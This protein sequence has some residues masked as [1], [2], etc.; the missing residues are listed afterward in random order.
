MKPRPR[1]FI[2]TATASARL[3]TCESAGP[4]LSPTPVFDEVPKACSPRDEDPMDISPVRDR[5]GEKRGAGYFD[6]PKEDRTTLTSKCPVVRSK[7]LYLRPPNMAHWNQRRGVSEPV[8]PVQKRLPRPCFKRQQSELAFTVTKPG[9]RDSDNVKRSSRLSDPMLMGVTAEVPR[10]QEP[11]V[12][13]RRTQSFGGKALEE[14]ESA[15]S[16]PTSLAAT[17]GHEEDCAL[18]WEAGKGDSHKRIESDTLAKLLDG[19]YDD[20][21]D[22]Y[23]IIDCR[24]PYEY[25]GGHIA[26]ARNINTKDQLDKM[27]FEN[28]VM[29]R[30]VVIV[31]HCEFSSHRAPTMATYMRRRDRSA[32]LD[33]YPMLYYPEIYVLKG[34]YKQFYSTHK[35]RCEP[36]QYIEMVHKE[37]TADLKK[38]RANHKREFGRSA[39]EGFLKQH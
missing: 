1:P 7:G 26:G 9:C 11:P 10:G 28:P 15:C 18:P 27:F 38:A 4:R 30:K 31:F 39:S 35:S 5:R 21:I 33:K 37:Y 17:Y 24:F 13:M 8:I 3:E 16:W 23:H 12:K 20:K 2:R 29:D 34:G 14:S 36:Q 32:N 25:E 19:Q 22:E 6:A